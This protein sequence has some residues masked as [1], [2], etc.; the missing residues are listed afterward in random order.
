MSPEII[1]GGILSILIGTS[2]YFLK[3]LLSDF[4]KVERDLAEVKSITALIKAE[5]KGNQELLNQKV[6]FMDNRVSRI[7]KLIFKIQDHEN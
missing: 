2:A 4:K 5:F 3:Q 6:E 7:E 1:I